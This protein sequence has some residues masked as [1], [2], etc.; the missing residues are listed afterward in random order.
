MKVDWRPVHQRTGARQQ[1]EARLDLSNRFE[2][3]GFAEYHSTTNVRYIDAGDVERRPLAGGGSLHCRPV[4]LNPA[5]P[6]F[7]LDGYS[8][9]SCS[10][11]T[12]PESNV[13]VTTVPKPCIENARSTGIRNHAAGIF[14]LRPRSATSAQ[15]I[16]QF[17][18][19]LVL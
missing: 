13:P 15:R 12:A 18:D 2:S 1:I 10:M 4:D 17:L 6:Y 14:R 7:T 5:H 9:D 16:F 11:P 19:A 8:S 3:A